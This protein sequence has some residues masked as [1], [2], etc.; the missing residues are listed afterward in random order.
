MQVNCF[1]QRNKFLIN[2]ALRVEDNVITMW[3]LTWVPLLGCGE[4]RLSHWEDSYL[5][6]GS[7]SKTRFCVSIQAVPSTQ[8]HSAAAVYWRTVEAETWWRWAASL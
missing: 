8:T 5:V 7:Y 6:S 3:N 2:D 4:I 1:A